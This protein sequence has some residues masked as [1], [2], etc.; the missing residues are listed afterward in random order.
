[1]ITIGLCTYN[2]ARYLDGA[3]RSIARLTLPDNLEYEV[4]LV[5]NNSTDDTA[6]VAERVSRRI[7][8]RVFSALRQGLSHARN[9]VL[10]EARG[11]LMLFT[12]DDVVL[13]PGWLGEYATAFSQFPQ[14]G[15]FGGRV[16][17]A[18]TNGR[19]A[20]LGDEN[21]PLISGLLVHYDRGTDVRLFT[22]DDPAPYG[23]SFG[24]TRRAVEAVGE[25][26][27]GLGVVGRQG[28]RGEE[29]D[30]IERL[31]A[32][33][34]TGVYV[35]TALAWHR[36]V[37]ERLTAHHALRH[38]M[39]K[40]TGL[41]S[42]RSGLGGLWRAIEYVVRGARQAL[43]GRRDRYLQSLICAGIELGSLRGRGARQP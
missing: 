36:T 8:I 16:L 26:D 41:H 30:Y 25:F 20:W 3:L 29:T 11:D 37:P 22:E 33:G 13:E 23:A 42:T 7:P 1:M 19:P 34:T 15:Y 12:D 9:R 24:L 39:S 32:A 28:G 18:W 5:D 40:A 17:A 2:R 21:M 35:G 10:R 31:R 4:V 6:Q 43:L 27:V 14:A 38:G